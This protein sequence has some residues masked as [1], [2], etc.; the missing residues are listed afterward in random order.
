M[1]VK[2]VGNIF[3]LYNESL[4]KKR[5]PSVDEKKQS[6][7]QQFD[8]SKFNF[9]KV[10]EKEILF[11][12]NIDN[13]EIIT[14]EKALENGSKFLDDDLEEADQQSENHPVIINTSPIYKNHALLVMFPES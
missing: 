12:V 3:A 5:A 4:K 11:Y 8:P 13:E 2:K 7:F 1:S 9:N 14:K 6:V 10:T